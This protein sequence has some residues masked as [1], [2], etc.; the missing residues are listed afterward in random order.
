MKVGP[1]YS[2]LC[3][4]SDCVESAYSAVSVNL[5]K[6]F[7]GNEF[8]LINPFTAMKKIV[9]GYSGQNQKFFPYVETVE[10]G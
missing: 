7:A 6:V 9:L 2:P 1:L 3:R 5:V 4:H 8:R 10:M